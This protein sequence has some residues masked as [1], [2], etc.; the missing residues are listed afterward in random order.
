MG[1]ER[2]RS[3]CVDHNRENEAY[4]SSLLHILVGLFYNGAS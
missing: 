2:I 1:V 3:E 4:K